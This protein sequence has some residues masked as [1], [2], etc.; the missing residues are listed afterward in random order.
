MN[1]RVMIALALSSRPRLLIADE[2]TTALDVTIEK[3][4]IR[5]LLELKVRFNFSILFITHNLAL[6]EKFA[7]GTAIMYQGRIVE[8]TH[9]HALEL[10]AA[11]IRL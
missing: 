7:S 3:E 2:P 9:P 11:V 8:K 1:Q 4:I 10:A 5:M 6:A